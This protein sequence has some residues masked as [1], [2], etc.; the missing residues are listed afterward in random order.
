MENTYPKNHNPKKSN[1]NL[2]LYAKNSFKPI[3]YFFM[4]MIKNH[5]FF[6]FLLLGL[7]AAIPVKTAVI[8]APATSVEAS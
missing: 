4:G 3:T 7:V 1:T 2:T 8:T 6:I 5:Y